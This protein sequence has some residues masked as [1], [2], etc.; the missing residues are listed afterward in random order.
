MSSRI[1]WYWILCFVEFHIVSYCFILFRAFPKKYTFGQH[2]IIILLV[3]FFYSTRTGMEKSA[4]VNL[5]RRQMMESGWTRIRWSES[6]MNSTCSIML[7][8]KMRLHFLDKRAIITESC[9][10]LDSKCL[11]EKQLMISLA[12]PTMADAWM[13][14]TLRMEH[15]ERRSI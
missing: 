12:W 3:Y 2:S 9:C 13:A 11:T 6:S 15:V 4:L 5:T 8:R 7:W 14:Q 1:L 10:T